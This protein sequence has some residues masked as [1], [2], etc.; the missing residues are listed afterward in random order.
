MTIKEWVYKKVNN[1]KK[2]LIENLLFS[3]GICTQEDVYEYTHPLESKLTSPDVFCDMQKAVDRISKAISNNEKIVIYGDFDADGITSTALLY[4]TLKYLG[5]D[6]N[7]FIPDRE[8]EGHGFET[9][10]LVNLMK[11]LKPKL[12]I[13]VDCGI[14]NV[15]EISFIKSFNVDVIITDHHEAPETLPAAFAIVNPKAPNALAEELSAKQI[16]SL[17]S[18]AGV[19]VAFKLAQALLTSHSKTEYI[20]E[21]LPY[22][23]VGTIADVVPLIGENRYFVV[24]GLDLIAQGKHLGIKRLIESAG[25]SAEKNLTSEV[26]AFGVAPRINASGRLETVEAAIK[27]LLSENPQEIELAVI[28]LNN[29][30]KVRQKLCQDVF[31]QADEMVKKECNNTPAIILFNSEWS[32]GIIGIVASKL[33]EKYYKPVFLMT[34]SEETQQ[35][36]CSARSIKGVHLYEVISTIGDCLDGYGGHA[37]AAGLTFSPKNIPYEKVKEK[38]NDAVKE[39]IKGKVLKPFL[40]ID[41][42]LLPQDITVDFVKELSTLEPFGAENPTPTFSLSDCKITQKRLMGDNNN[43]LRLTVSKEDAIFTCIRWQE[44]DTPLKEGDTLDIAFQPQINEYNG[45]I[46]VQL[47]IKDIHSSNLKEEIIEQTSSIKIYDHRKKTDILPQV[48]DYIKSS[49]LNIKLF[50]ESRNIT[51][52]LTKYDYLKNNIITRNDIKPCDAIMF[53]DYPADIQTFKNIISQACPKAIHLMNYEIKDF[54]GK[55]FLKTISGMIKYACNKTDGNIDLIRAAGFLGKSITFLKLVLNL[56]E[57]CEAVKIEQKS[58]T[59]YKLKLISIDNIPSILYNS[60]YE[61]VLEQSEECELFQKMLLEEDTSE[62]ASMLE[63]TEI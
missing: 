51:D 11:N 50:A 47:I 31:E 3:R 17:A 1:D 43:H 9:K 12:I 14:S 34:F 61:S 62:I 33:V 53:F 35:I 24:K 37:L 30:N 4:K 45:D 44:G 32:V 59:C 56:L 40:E 58:D 2:S 5:A 15:K 26:I 39:A 19:G 49:K 54:D 41:M 63:S 57:E 36:K 6:V 42:E 10:A 29:L 23:A 13:S 16:N 22:V 48:N 21:I 28:E 60:K 18:L 27:L 8:K 55:E 25:Y 7:Y 20:Q 46:S 38:L 52:F